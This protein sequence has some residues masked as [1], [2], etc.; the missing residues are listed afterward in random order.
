MITIYV[1]YSGDSDT[2]FDR[3]YYVQKHLPLVREGWAAHGLASAAAFFPAEDGP[4][5]I[6]LCVCTFRDAAAWDA[7]V[8]SPQ[9]PGIMADIANFTAVA[10][11]RSQAVAL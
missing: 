9:T 6:A 11:A 10:P 3:E 8:R 1:A 7:A 4:G 2:R 5:I